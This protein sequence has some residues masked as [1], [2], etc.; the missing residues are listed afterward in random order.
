MSG[1][2]S[3]KAALPPRLAMKI[4]DLM[5]FKASTLMA[6]GFQHIE[7]HKARGAPPQG[8]RHRQSARCAATNSAT[9]A[10]GMMPNSRGSMPGPVAR[11]G[12]RSRVWSVPVQV[13]SLP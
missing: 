10:N 3:D 9:P 4:A 6:I 7:R 13:G 12:T 2:A 5:R 8:R 1:P 11:T